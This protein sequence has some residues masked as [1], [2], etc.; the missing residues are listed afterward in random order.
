MA[1]QAQTP[2]GSEHY[3]HRHARQPFIL[4]Q[5]NRE[6]AE[7]VWERKDNRSS[8][9]TADCGCFTALF[10]PRC[11]S[12]LFLPMAGR[13]GQRS[14][15]QLDDGMVALS[16][17]AEYL[18]GSM[19]RSLALN[20]FCPAR[21]GVAGSCL[22]WQEQCS[23]AGRQQVAGW[24]FRRS[25]SSSSLEK[26]DAG[27]AGKGKM[28]CDGPPLHGPCGDPIPCPMPGLLSWCTGVQ[29]QQWA[30]SGLGQSSGQRSCLP[31]WRVMDK[32]QHH[33]LGDRDQGKPSRQDKH[34]TLPFSHW[35][36]ITSP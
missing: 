25:Q 12:S 6:A 4:K 27:E 2:R 22:C 20:S 29:S 18:W 1:L 19:A 36:L 11:E 15:R 26:R 32:V 33:P 10:M 28:F 31:D 8:S 21:M 23:G 9:S 34:Y 24:R 16:G 17:T 14:I 3:C 13:A 30:V 5:R 7:T 35:K